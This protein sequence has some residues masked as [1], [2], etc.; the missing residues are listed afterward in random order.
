MFKQKL[1]V[2]LISRKIRQVYRTIFL[3]ICQVIDF[4]E[5]FDI[6]FISSKTLFVSWFDRLFSNNRFS[7]RVFNFQMNRIILK[8]WLLI[9]F[10]HKNL[11]VNQCFRK[12]FNRFSR[13]Y[14]QSLEQIFLK[15]FDFFFKKKISKLIMMFKQKI[16]GHP[17]FTKNSKVNWFFTQ[18]LYQSINFL[19]E[20]SPFNRVMEIFVNHSI[21]TKNFKSFNDISHS[22]VC[23]SI[24]LKKWSFNRLSWVV[25]SQSIYSL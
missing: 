19:I 13:K 22:R 2:N 12:H 4:I 5:I 11:L 17:I 10:S 20:N 25:V 21:F 14:H 1:S 24:F 15:I 23:Q 16:K 18:K 9:R 3:K 6:T 8:N 7:Q